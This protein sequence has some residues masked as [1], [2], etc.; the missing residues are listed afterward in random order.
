MKSVTRPSPY[1]MASPGA[2]AAAGN[3]AATAV[4]ADMAIRRWRCRRAGS[5]RTRPC[6]HPLPQS[7]APR[8]RAM[9][10]QHRNRSLS[11]GSGASATAPRLRRLPTSAPQPAIEGALSAFESTIRAETNEQC[12]RMFKTSL[13]LGEVRADYTQLRDELWSEPARAQQQA[14]AQ[15]AR[16]DALSQQLIHLTA[17]VDQLLSHPTHPTTHTH[18]H[19]S[20]HRDTG[21]HTSA[22][23]ASSALAAGNQRTDVATLVIFPQVLASEVRR[24]L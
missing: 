4:V 16:L 9:L 19:R 7:P 10:R 3:I 6:T 13:S 23:S 21:H 15:S 20:V 1:G 2:P 17:S 24:L 12:D 22:S 11:P 8:L 14:A 18:T 5:H